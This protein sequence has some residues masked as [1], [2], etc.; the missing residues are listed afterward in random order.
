MA[1]V[2]ILT[3]HNNGAAV[4]NPTT[5]A[6]F[7]LSFRGV[8]SSAIPVTGLNHSNLEWALQAISTISDVRVRVS[9]AGAMPGVCAFARGV[10]VC[11]CCCVSGGK[12]MATFQ[13]S[14]FY[15]PP[16]PSLSPLHSHS[17]HPCPPAMC[18]GIEHVISSLSH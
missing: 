14:G 16:P 10:C 11:M 5:N 13:C 9:S 12:P 7:V 6:Y 17:H 4:A 1:E 2:Q 18:L 3:V 8:N 15:T